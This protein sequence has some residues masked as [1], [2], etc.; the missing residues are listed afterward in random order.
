MGG[1][2]SLFPEPL[3]ADIFHS[4]DLQAFLKKHEKIKTFP[5]H[6]HQGSEENVKESNIG[7]N[8]EIAIRDFL[9]FVRE[10]M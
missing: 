8:P 9:K 6:F 7:D 5:K 3:D 2:E 10:N 1:S 4:N